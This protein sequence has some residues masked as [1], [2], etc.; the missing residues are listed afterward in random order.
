MR[1]AAAYLSKMKAEALGRTFKVQDTN[2]RAFTSTLYRGAAGCGPVDYTQIEYRD[3]CECRYIGPARNPFGPGPLNP[4]RRRIL[5]GGF[6]DNGVLS[7]GFPDTT[8]TSQQYSG[9]SPAA[10]G[11]TVLNG[12]NQRDVLNGGAVNGSSSAIFDGGNI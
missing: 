1:T 2:H 12:N 6:P 7:G 3:I 9:G 11:P 5:D 10:S 8:N 4:V